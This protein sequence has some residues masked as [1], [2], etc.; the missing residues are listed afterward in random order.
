MKH[1]LCVL[2]V[3]C[4][5]PATLIDGTDSISGA[6]DHSARACSVSYAPRRCSHGDSAAV[7][8]PTSPTPCV[9]SGR[10]TSP[11]QSPTL[12]PLHSSTSPP[13]LVMIDLDP[14][15][16]G[17]DSSTFYCWAEDPRNASMH[18]E[19]FSMSVNKDMFDYFSQPQ[20]RIKPASFLAIY[21]LDPLGNDDCPVGLCPNPDIAGR[22][23]RIA[24]TSSLV[25]PADRR[26]TLPI[27]QITSPHSV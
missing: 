11:T 19:V 13:T 22:L 4:T 16:L 24:R 15:K 8:R 14:R 1:S 21:C 20:G 9:P 27:Y 6:A 7:L 2:D 3:A 17:H 10:W 5:A 18:E 25:P 23:L 12:R 26:L